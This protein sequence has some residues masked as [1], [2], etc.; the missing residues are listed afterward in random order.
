MKL[1]TKKAREQH[2]SALRDATIKYIEHGVKAWLR[3]RLDLD[4][5]DMTTKDAYDLGC[6][7]G[8]IEDDQICEAFEKASNLDTAVR[9]EIPTDT[10]NWL[11]NARQERLRNIDE[12]MA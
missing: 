9:D 11:A 2:A 6:I 7:V 10:W 8:M 4:M 3:D 1:N 5:W 12:M